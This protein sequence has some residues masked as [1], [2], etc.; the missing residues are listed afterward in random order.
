[1][2]ARHAMDTHD[3][4]EGSISGKL[5]RFF[6]PILFGML[7][8]QL[9]NTVDAIIVG[10]CVGP[11][12]L[13]AVGGSPAVITNL[14]IGF[15]IGLSSGATVIISQYFGSHEDEQLSRAVHTILAFCLIIGAALT[16][17]GWLTA[18]WALRLVR[19]PEDIFGISNEYLCIYYVGAIP[20]LLFNVGSA[21]LRA[22]GDARWPLL[23]LVVCCL[24]NIV[25]DLLFVAGFHM[26]TAGAGWATVLS[27]AV[28]AVC[29]LL[30]LSRSP[31]AERLVWRRL[32]IHPGSLRRILYI[33]V[34]AGIQSAMY[35]VSNLI[36]QAAVNMLGTTVVAA[37]TAATKFDGLYWVT[38]NSLGVAICTFVGQCYGAGKYD[39]MKAGIRL[40][41]LVSLGISAGISV[42]LLGIAPFGLRLFTDD[43][44]VIRQA[45]TMMWYFVP[46]YVVWTFI[47]IFSNS[48]RGAGD[49]FVPMLIILTGVCLLRMLWIFLV[50]PHWHTVISVS[51]SYPISWIITALV[52]IVYFYKGNWLKRSAPRA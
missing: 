11:Q 36:I 43:R 20:L 34:P 37:W 3:L 27:L 6:F 50:V 42:F 17:L 1:M 30:H 46:Y 29:I 26:G 39:R 51:I 22:V 52:F 4:T 28:S 33:G 49:S 2:E 13:A 41:L 32:R 47:E 10:K 38:S 40:W 23:F 16:V 15:F 35:A 9:Y 24:L 12:A 19:T 21:I 25:L 45:I 48:L 31:G 18:P 5:L 8:Q 14:V 7:F 44:E